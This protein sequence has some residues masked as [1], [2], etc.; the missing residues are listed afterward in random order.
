MQVL[1]QLSYTP[2]G[3]TMLPVESRRSEFN[4]YAISVSMYET[5]QSIALSPNEP[6]R[7]FRNVVTLLPCRFQPSLDGDF[8]LL[9]C[10]LRRISVT[11]AKC[12]IWDVG[13]PDLIFVTPK[14]LN[15]INLPHEP[16]SNPKLYRRIMLAI[17]RT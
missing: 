12:Q 5:S 9:D 2:K 7:W 13:N 14:H 3:I 17:W 1:Y 15:R 16:S 6:L 11:R 10:S 4:V 8:D